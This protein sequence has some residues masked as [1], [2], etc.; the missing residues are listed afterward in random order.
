MEA[1]GT[2]AYDEIK[3]YVLEKYSLEESSLYI[4]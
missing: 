2:A 4:S 3:A 1:E